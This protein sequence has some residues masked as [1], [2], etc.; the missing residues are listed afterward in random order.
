MCPRFDDLS[1]H[2]SQDELLG[3]ILRSNH[4]SIGMTFAADERQKKQED[5]R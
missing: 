5:K 3:K 1:E 2:L 4:D